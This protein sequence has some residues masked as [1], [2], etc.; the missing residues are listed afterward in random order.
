V[1]DVMHPDERVMALARRQHGVVTSAQLADAGL[2]PRA[3]A[4]RVARGRLKRLHHGVYLVAS[5]PA[6]LTFEM[7]AV[8][9][10]PPPAGLS[11]HSG[12]ALWGLRP[13]LPGD[14]DVTVL[15]GTPRPRPGIRVHRARN[16][17][18]IARHQ[19]SVTTPARTLLDLAP[20]LPRA[21]FDRALEEAQVQRLVTLRAIEAAIQRGHPGAGRVRK[22]LQRL[23]DP[24]LT[25]SEAEARLLDLIRAA[26]LPAPRTNVQVLGYEVDLLWPD[27]RLIVEVDGYAFHSTRQAFERDRL[28]DA[29]LQA[30]G[31]AVIRV[32]WRQIVETPHAVAALVA[33][34]LATNGSAS[35]DGRPEAALSPRR[36]AS[37]RDPWRAGP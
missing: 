20:L 29:R 9:A 14:I 7:A 33:A 27:N 10:C 13:R 26:D 15:G 5:L 21:Q 32:T 30:A 25:R 4:H 1:G 35:Q 24:A 37:G 18:L 6:S 36:L 11:H 34:A 22:A 19:I 2:S 16:L 31:Y 28:R 3:V 12:A 23:T 17:E 8:L